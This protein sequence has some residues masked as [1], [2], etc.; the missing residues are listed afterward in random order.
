MIISINFQVHAP[1]MG[2]NGIAQE[3]AKKYSILLLLLLKL[4]GRPFLVDWPTDRPQVFISAIQRA[5]CPRVPLGLSEISVTQQPE[6][7]AE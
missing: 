3:A 4:N 7:D 1:W 2:W 5:P 6:E